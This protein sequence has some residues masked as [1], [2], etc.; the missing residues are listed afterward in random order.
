MH[1]LRPHLCPR[2]AYQQAKQSDVEQK[3]IVQKEDSGNSYMYVGLE[4]LTVWRSFMNNP[5]T[6]IHNLKALNFCIH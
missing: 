5:T 4:Y 2:A 3:I 6:E 1:S